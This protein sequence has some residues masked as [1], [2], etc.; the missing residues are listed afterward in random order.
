MLGIV[1]AVHTIIDEFREVIFQG[2]IWNVL[3]SVLNSVG[4]TLAILFSCIRSELAF[5]TAE[6]SLSLAFIPYALSVNDLRFDAYDASAI[7][8]KPLS[9]ILEAVKCD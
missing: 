2:L 1:L 3:D 9:R 6:T 4:H 5:A 7:V 8:S